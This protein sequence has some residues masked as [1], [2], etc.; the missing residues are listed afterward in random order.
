MLSMEHWFYEKSSFMLTEMEQ[1]CDLNTREETKN[2][3]DESAT[4]SLVTCAS[5]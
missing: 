1:N 2:H 5:N 4:Y 3:S